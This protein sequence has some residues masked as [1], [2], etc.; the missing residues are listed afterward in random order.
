MK[1]L[2][3]LRVKTG[4]VANGPQKGQ[5]YEYVM[6]DLVDV[7]SNTARKSQLCIMNP[8]LVGVYK[9]FICKKNGGNVDRDVNPELP[10]EYKGI[11]NIS[12]VNVPLNGK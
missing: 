11:G 6:A 10:D 2:T 4:V 8:T 3:N 9:N 5:P 7:E 12:C 1:K